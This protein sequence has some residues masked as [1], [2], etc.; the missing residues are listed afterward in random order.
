MRE[1]GHDVDNFPEYPHRYEDGRVVNV[2]LYPNELLPICQKFLVEDWLKN[3]AKD[4]FAKRDKDALA[5][6]QKMMNLP[7][8]REVMGYIDLK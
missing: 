7:N 8:L 3:I 5:Y 4:Y 2:R 1:L 6:L